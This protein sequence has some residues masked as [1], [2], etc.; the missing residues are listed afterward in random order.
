MRQ[1]IRRG[2]LSVFGGGTR[3][4]ALAAALL[5]SGCGRSVL[6]TAPVDHVAG[7]HS[8]A[9]GELRYVCT[10]APSTALPKETPVGGCMRTESIE[11]EGRR[12]TLA[13]GMRN[14][15]CAIELARCTGRSASFRVREEGDAVLAV[16]DAAGADELHAMYLA[17]GARAL[18][19]RSVPRASTSAAA[20]LASMPSRTEA[21]NA[22]LRSATPIEDANA[23]EDHLWEHLA[24]EEALR[25][26]LDGVTERARRCALPGD[27]L[28]RFVAV[29]GDDA[30]DVLYD[31]IAKRPCPAATKL[32]VD[33]RPP[34]LIPKIRADLERASP[35]ASSVVARIEVAAAYGPSMASAIDA[36]LRRTVLDYQGRTPSPTNQQFFQ[37]LGVLAGL[38]PQPAARLVLD[39]LRA[40]PP[41]TDVEDSPWH[42][43]PDGEPIRAP[44]YFGSILAKLDSASV[45]SELA[46]VARDARAA[47]A[48]R[49]VALSVLGGLRDPS[50]DGVTDV[51]LSPIQWSAIEYER[52]RPR[53]LP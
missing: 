3:R 24:T 34:A 11:L 48:A 52:A 39:L 7:I 2:E 6:V 16:V 41:G 26:H 15:L 28:P 38:D 29:R 25:R 36:T 27:V 8:T 1:A 47:P 21:I 20:L 14:E 17:R 51:A 31:A 9:L 33:R 19:W 22:R 45:R 4:I 10:V 44:L 46:A 5:A 13:Y 12:T 53:P 42:A 43:V 37:S 49:K 32:L 30:F 23:V 18:R 40:L 35:H 50:F